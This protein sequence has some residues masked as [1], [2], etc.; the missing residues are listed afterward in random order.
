MSVAGASPRN[1]STA[2]LIASWNAAFVTQEQAEFLISQI[3]KNRLEV[4]KLFSIAPIYHIT[5][6]NIIYHSICLGCCRFAGH[7]NREI[8]ISLSCNR[9]Y[10]PGDTPCQLILFFVGGG[11]FSSNFTFGVGFKK[12]DTMEHLRLIVPKAEW[13]SNGHF[14]LG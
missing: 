7:I 3:R 2:S 8:L 10:V 12:R 6:H 4:Y 9:E 1:A 13:N 11:R 5:R 14:Y